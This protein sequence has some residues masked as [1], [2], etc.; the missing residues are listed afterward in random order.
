[1]WKKIE[2][3]NKLLADQGAG[4]VQKKPG[5]GNRP[6]LYGFL[7]QS[8]FDAVNKILGPEGWSHTIDEYIV[9]EKQAI[10][11]VTVLIEPI[12][13]SQFGE[14]QVVISKS[15]GFGDVGSALKGAVTDAIQ[16]ALALWGVGSA[17]YRGQLKDVFDG[18][19]SHTVVGEEDLLL[20]TAKKITTKEIGRTF[21][22]NN[23]AEI[24]RLSPEA[25]NE[26]VK[27]LENKHD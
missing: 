20:T 9:N 2:A 22:K 12:S 3:I 19:F 6:A 14:S 21:W 7:P 15:S 4:V 17:A 13:H 18:K 8:V 26:L 23:L 25:R 10:A 11:K 5:L 1:M 16:K 27:E 24:Q